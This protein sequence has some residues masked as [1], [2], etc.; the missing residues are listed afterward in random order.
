MTHLLMCRKLLY[1]EP[2]QFL[3]HYYHF[4]AELLFGTWAFLC[5]VLSRTTLPQSVSLNQPSFNPQHSGPQ[6]AISRAIFIHADAEGWR[7]SPGFNAHV[8]RAV[9]PSVDVEVEKDW[10]DRIAATSNTENRRAWH[11]PLA[12]L[13]DRSASHRGDA[14]GSR[15]QRIAAEAWEFMMKAGAIDSTGRWWESIRASIL[16]FSRAQDLALVENQAVLGD[17]SDSELGY[18]R[19]I[20]ITYIDRQNV[21]RHLIEED[22]EGLVK[23]LQD[24]IQKKKEEGKEWELNII[25][26]ETLTKDEQVRIASRTSV[27]FA[28]LPSSRLDMFVRF[29]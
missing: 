15:T 24:L 29:Y 13:A 2:S 5:G 23:A 22:H 25:K 9:F 1:N 10:S 27:S 14:C 4:V 20:V 8:L 12:L 16:Q 17:N 18:P 26:P 28:V 21:R 6:P 7:D 3:N 19:K 11:F